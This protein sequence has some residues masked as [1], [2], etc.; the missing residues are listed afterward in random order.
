MPYIKAIVKAMVPT[1]SWSYSRLLQEFQDD[2]LDLEDELEATT[3][4]EDGGTPSIHA[5]VEVRAPGRRE[6]SHTWSVV[7]PRNPQPSPCTVR[8]PTTPLDRLLDNPSIQLYPQHPE[9][10]TLDAVQNVSEVFDALYAQ[11][12]AQPQEEAAQPQEEALPPRPR[13]SYRQYR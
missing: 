8:H 3:T 5:E 10:V 1:H 11:E 7:T 9:L 2:D 4:V 6:N 12:P 13:P